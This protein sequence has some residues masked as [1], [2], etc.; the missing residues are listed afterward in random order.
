MKFL[1]KS[2]IERLMINSFGF[3]VHEDG[4][5]SMEGNVCSETCKVFIKDG[6]FL[7]KFKEIKGFFDC[8]G[9]GLISLEGCPDFVGG[10]F[11]ASD[12]QL[13]N[14]VGSPKKVGKNCYFHT[15]P[16]IS[17]EGA[18]KEVDG[19]FDV[20]MCPL[21]SLED[22]PEKINGRYDCNLC[23]KLK[24]L[25]GIPKDFPIEKIDVPMEVPKTT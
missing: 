23:S 11:D 5:I 18:P 21:T 25:K 7:V 17:L 4:T 9:C 22:G 2:D 16:L 10:W 6:R 24:S 3:N 14:L 19:T 1:K 8:S 15:N 13:T 12:N 20:A